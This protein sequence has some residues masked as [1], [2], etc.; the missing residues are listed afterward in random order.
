VKP[1]RVEL[2]DRD[3]KPANAPADGVELTWHDEIDPRRVRRVAEILADIL[4]NA[5]QSGQG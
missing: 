4:D 3:L 2:D 5:R 1:A